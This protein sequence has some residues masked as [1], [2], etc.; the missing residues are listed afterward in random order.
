MR[1]E[2]HR[3][4]S[5]GAVQ[6]AKTT[7]GNRRTLS[8]P[9]A[10]RQAKLRRDQPISPERSAMMARIGQRNTA[11]EITVRRILHRLG[12][13]FRLH[14]HD[15]PGTPDIVLP[16][17]RTAILVH[18]CF[19]HRHA[20]CRFAYMPKSRIEFWKAKFERNVA[21]D[22]EVEQ[23]LCG[24]GWRVHIVWECETADLVVLEK[25]LRRLIRGRTPR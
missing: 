4:L 23:A 8:V 3:A 15:L 18:G 20:G 1:K 10:D 25:R 2:E 21:R 12:I 24:L 5:R 13:R 7:T 19:W 6:I 14:R 16:S 22:A 11:P 17:R 9:P